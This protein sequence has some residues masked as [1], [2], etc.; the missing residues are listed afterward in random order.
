MGEI[1]SDKIRCFKTINNF[2]PY[3][4]DYVPL[5][6]KFTASEHI[7]RCTGIIHNKEND[8]NFIEQHCRAVKKILKDSKDNVNSGHHWIAKYREA[9]K[10]VDEIMSNDRL[11]KSQGLYPTSAN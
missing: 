11:K 5:D 1:S 8:K 7:A 9:I 3:S 2:Y 4:R 6:S 10:C